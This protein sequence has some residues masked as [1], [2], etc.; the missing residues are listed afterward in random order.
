[1]DLTSDATRAQTLKAKD[2]AFNALNTE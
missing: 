2:K 1:V